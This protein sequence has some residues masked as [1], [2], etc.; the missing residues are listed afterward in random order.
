MNLGC[1][2]PTSDHITYLTINMETHLHKWEM[3]SSKLL[4]QTTYQEVIIRIFYLYVS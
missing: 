2:H 3:E 1:Y 4:Q